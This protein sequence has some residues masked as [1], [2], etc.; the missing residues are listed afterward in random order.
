MQDNDFLIRWLNEWSFKKREKSRFTHEIHKY[1][2]T[3]LPEVVSKIIETYSKQGETVLD[4]FSGSGTT[5]L[6]SMILGRKSIGIELNPLACLISKVKTTPIN[7]KE[8]LKYLKTIKENY[9]QKKYQNIVF[10]NIEYWFNPETSIY[11]SSLLGSINEIENEDIK[12]FSKISLSNILRNISYC[13]HSG[14]KM[15]RDRK[16]LSLNLE[17]NDLF[18]LFEESY[19]KNSYLLDSLNNKNISLSL[20]PK[21]IN[22]DSTKFRKDIPLVDLIVTS[23]PYGDSPTTVAYGQF[24]RLSSQFLNL[25]SLSGIPIARLDNDLLGGK[26]SEINFEEIIKTSQTLKNIYELFTLRSKSSSSKKDKSKIE[27]RLND[28]ITFYYDLFLCIKNS[29]SYLK[30]EKYLILVTASRVVHEVKLHTD[31]IITEFALSLGMKLKN[32]HY[33]DIHNK[34]MPSKVSSTNI[35]GE[36]TPTMTMES[37]IVLQKK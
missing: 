13:K 33:R 14:F 5:L 11:I 12:D 7:K 4:I 37:I 3:F 26:K 32:I 35:K 27:A 20:K 23:P 28:I 19:I 36:I 9:F 1:P 21:I 30:E 29:I 24:S 10:E 22:G 31:I 25:K 6:E 8:I 16:K 34:R 18:D 2:A 17:K 15:H